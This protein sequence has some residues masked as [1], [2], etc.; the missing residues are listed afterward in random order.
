MWSGRACG[1]GLSKVNL[2]SWRGD[3]AP[4]GCRCLWYEYVERHK[5]WKSLDTG[6]LS[7]SEM[8]DVQDSSGRDGKGRI[9]KRMLSLCFSG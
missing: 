2:G 5:K 7:K 4:M 8:V 9:D 3:G 6:W 1:E